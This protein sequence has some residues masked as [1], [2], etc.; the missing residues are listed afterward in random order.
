VTGLYSTIDDIAKLTPYC[1]T[2]A[3]IR[4]RQLLSAAKL[5]E[6]LDKTKAMGLPSRQ[7]NQFGERRYHRSLWSVPALPRGF[8]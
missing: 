5:A 2:A 8:G 4:G 6:A 1:S 7:E 3:N